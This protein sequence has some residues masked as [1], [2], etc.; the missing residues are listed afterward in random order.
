MPLLP[1]P[2]NSYTAAGRVDF[3][4]IPLLIAIRKPPALL[5]RI[6]KALPFPT[7]FPSLYTSRRRLQD[8]SPLRP[9]AGGSR[10]GN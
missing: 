6:D 8:P 2:V 10:F 1:R 7:L 4:S 5:V 9:R 3:T